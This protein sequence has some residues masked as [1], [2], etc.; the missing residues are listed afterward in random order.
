MR[1][2]HDMVFGS[3]GHTVEVVIVHPLAKV[4]F[5]AWDDVAYIPALYGIV[6][7]LFHQFIGLIEMTL[8]IANRR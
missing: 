1:I 7:I 2:D 4:M 5:S 3:L 6:A 8:I